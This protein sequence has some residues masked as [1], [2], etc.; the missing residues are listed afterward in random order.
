MQLIW[1]DITL[2]DHATG[3]TVTDGAVVMTLL[4]VEFNI[5]FEVQ[6]TISLEY[7][8]CHQSGL[9]LDIAIQ[10]LLYIPHFTVIRPNSSVVL[11]LVRIQ[12]ILSVQLRH[13]SYDLVSTLL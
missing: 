7:Q 8:P 2:H 6:P 3:C 10:T 11:R 5:N 12:K 13:V 4:M 1:S 9:V